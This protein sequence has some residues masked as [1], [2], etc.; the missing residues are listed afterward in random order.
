MMRSIDKVILAV[1]VLCCASQAL[2]QT[3]AVTNSPAAENASELTEGQ[4]M[5]SI[6]EDYIRP[7]SSL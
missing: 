4:W 6:E 5:F 3:D 1:V 7:V 2:C